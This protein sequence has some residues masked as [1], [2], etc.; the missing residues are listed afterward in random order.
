MKYAALLVIALT[1]TSCAHVQTGISP[2][3]DIANAGGKIEEAA[4]TIFTTVVQI[5][6]TSPNLISQ[7]ATDQVAIAVNKIGHTGLILNAALSS[8]NSA[9]AAGSDLTAQKATIQQI[10]G[11][12]S[13]AMTDVGKALPPG[14]IQT[15]DALVNTIVD[16]VLQIKTGVGL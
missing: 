4:H 1:F 16:L 7:Q 3:A 5:R 9:K 10:L 8:Y 13:E 12:V 15:I 14:T 2:V 11:T 6:Q